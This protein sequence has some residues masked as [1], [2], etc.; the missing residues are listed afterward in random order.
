[1]C[2]DNIHILIQHHLRLKINLLIF[3]FA[4]NRYR[5]LC[6]VYMCI[7]KILTAAIKTL[8]SSCRNHR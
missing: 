1:M 7:Y 2:L 6:V 5:W 3:S 8:R 4:E